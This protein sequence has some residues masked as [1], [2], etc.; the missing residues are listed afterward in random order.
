MLKWCLTKFTVAEFF[1]SWIFLLFQ[2]AVPCAPNTLLVILECLCA[3]SVC[4]L[5]DTTFWLSGSVCHLWFDS[6]R[7]SRPNSHS[8]PLLLLWSRCSAVHL[9]SDVRTGEVQVPTR[10]CAHLEA[11]D[12]ISAGVRVIY[13]KETSCLYPEA[14]EFIL[15]NAMEGRDTCEWDFWSVGQEKSFVSR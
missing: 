4:R 14:W 3:E 5:A 10:C 9:F 1:L 2:E 12:I 6:W 8:D 7:Q 15:G 13:E 11:G